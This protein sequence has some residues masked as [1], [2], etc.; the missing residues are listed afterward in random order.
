MP[1][2]QGRTPFCG[3]CSADSAC[4]KTHVDVADDVGVRVTIA[5][6]ELALAEPRFE[7]VEI[8]LGTA[9]TAFGERRN[10]LVRHR[11]AERAPLER[12]MTVAQSLLQTEVAFEGLN[13]GPHQYQR[14]F[15]GVMTH[16]VRLGMG[17]LQVVADGEALR[18]TRA[19]VELEHGHRGARILREKLGLELGP[20]AQ[21]DLYGRY[22][23]L[24]LGNE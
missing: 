8:D 11:T 14:L 3:R 20:R 23:E 24:L 12:F 21:V 9:F 19:I 22:V 2:L 10:L 5:G 1:C 4:G 13:V 15:L 17:S 7:L 16:E 18:E 6:D